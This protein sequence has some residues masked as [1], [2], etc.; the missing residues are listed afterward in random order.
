M[1]SAQFGRGCGRSGA[2]EQGIKTFGV[3][4]VPLFIFRDRLAVSSAQPP[5]NLLK[6]FVQAQELSGRQN[7]RGDENKSAVHAGGYK[8]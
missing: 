6:A 1:A 3:S 8:A 4:A 2:E 5:E 7:N